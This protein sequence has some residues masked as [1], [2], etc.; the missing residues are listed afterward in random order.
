MDSKI[1]ISYTVTHQ[2]MGD[3]ATPS[4]AV[5]FASYVEQQLTARY[6]T[7]EID[8]LVNPRIFSSDLSVDGVDEYEIEQFIK[9]CWDRGNWW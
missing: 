4:D 6:P 8:V 1:S 3:D 5:R 7:A 9:D 2:T